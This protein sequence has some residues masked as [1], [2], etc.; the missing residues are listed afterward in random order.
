MGGEIRRMAASGGRTRTGRG[1][2]I[3]GM[4]D[5]ETGVDDLHLA[6]VVINVS[7][8]ERAVRFWNAALG[9]RQRESEWGPTFM[10]LVHPKG[11]RLPVSLQLTDTDPMEPVRVHLDLYTSEQARHVLA[12]GR[13]GCHSRRRLA[14]S[15]G[16]R[17]HRAARP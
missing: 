12:A 13:A 14:L 4:A 6:T 3:A 8:M 7:D 10:M 17:L 16:C 5:T 1:H 15:R 9:Y 11:T 2:T